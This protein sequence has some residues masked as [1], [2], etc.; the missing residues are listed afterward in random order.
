MTPSRFRSRL[1][2]LAAVFAAFA[3]CDGATP[4][5]GN[6]QAARPDPRPQAI[7]AQRR[8]AITEA[9]AR[10]SPS[11]VT[12]QTEAVQRVTT[13]DFFWGPQSRE[14]T[15][16][17]I[18]SGF[19]IRADG[20]ILTNAHVIA[21]ATKPDISSGESLKRAVLAA[22]KLVNQ[23]KIFAMIA[24]IGTATHMAAIRARR[25]V[26]ISICVLPVSLHLRPGFDI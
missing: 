19:V 18:G 9:V 3:A 16:A 14:Q 25:I 8:T 6:A 22:Q 5:A 1:A 20:V 12:V 13:Y 2:A 23:D 11:V 17:G 4:H 7:A 10:V 24:H 15:S 26:K 21:G